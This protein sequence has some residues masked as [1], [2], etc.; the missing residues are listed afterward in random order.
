MGVV[1][2]VFVEEMIDIFFVMD[3]RC[4]ELF[5]CEGKNCQSH[6]R[7]NLPR[8]FREKSKRFS[9]ADIACPLLGCADKHFLAF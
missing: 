1:V 8:K 9:I 5:G 3:A 2:V 7:E 4:E 6:P